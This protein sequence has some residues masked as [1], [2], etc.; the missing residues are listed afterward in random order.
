MEE[1][2]FT[3]EEKELLELIDYALDLYRGMVFDEEAENEK[4][5]LFNENSEQLKKQIISFA[6]G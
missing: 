2:V 6:N 1:E 4:L 5:K 3:A